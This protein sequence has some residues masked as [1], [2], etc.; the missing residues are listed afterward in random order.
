[1]NEKF[2]WRVFQIENH[3][4][5]AEFPENRFQAPAYFG[6]MDRSKNNLAETRRTGFLARR[7]HD[8]LGRPSYGQFRK[9]FFGWYYGGAS[10]VMATGYFFV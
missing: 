4:T 5:P 7:F 6:T 1:M 3:R 8:G 10:W 9:L 2:F